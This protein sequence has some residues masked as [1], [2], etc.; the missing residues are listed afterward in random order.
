MDSAFGN[1][2]SMDGFMQLIEVKNIPDEIIQER[3]LWGIVEYVFKHRGSKDYKKI[4]KVLIPWIQEIE[5]SGE[6]YSL[7]ENVLT[8]WIDGI[9]TED[10]ESVKKELQSCLEIT[11]GAKK[12]TLGQLLRAE[13]HEIGLQE[14]INLGITKGIT[15][16]INQ[17]EA[18]VLLRQLKRRF[19]KVPANYLK[20]IQQADAETLLVWS[21]RILDAKN[22]EEIFV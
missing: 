21:D 22:L 12:M 1:F 14:G 13:G 11:L 8:Y 5:A 16:G 19:Y 9:E 18:A 2:S 3:R 6:V 15:K 17:G 7:C 10:V 4:L 20:K